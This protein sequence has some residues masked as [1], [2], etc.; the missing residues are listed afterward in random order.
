MYIF[1]GFWLFHRNSIRFRSVNQPPMTDADSGI[2][3]VEMEDVAVSFL[4][5]FPLFL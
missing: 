3:N 1:I 5:S 4:I 2:E